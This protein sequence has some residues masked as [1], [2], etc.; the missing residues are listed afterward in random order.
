MWLCSLQQGLVNSFV[1]KLFCF[2]TLSTDRHCHRPRY[3]TKPMCISTWFVQKKNV[4]WTETVLNTSKRGSEVK[5]KKKKFLRAEIGCLVTF[6]DWVSWENSATRQV[7]PFGFIYLAW[8][9][10]H[11]SWGYKEGGTG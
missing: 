1:F 8:L 4:R 11:R 7:C 10:L 2:V 5:K 3:L 6:R 9:W